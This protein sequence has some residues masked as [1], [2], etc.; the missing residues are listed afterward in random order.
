MPRH[1]I[2]LKFESQTRF[3]SVCMIHEQYQEQYINKYGALLRYGMY[4]RCPLILTYYL[5]GSLTVSDTVGLLFKICN[6]ICHRSRGA[7]AMGRVGRA[8]MHGIHSPR[9]SPSATRTQNRRRKSWR[10]PRLIATA[11]VVLSG[12][13]PR[14]RLHRARPVGVAGCHHLAPCPC[15]R[16]QVTAPTASRSYTERELLPERDV[17]IW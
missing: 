8:R 5:R 4:T 2:V 14:A 10:Q 11:C 13:A 15:C 17:G 16:C 6:C 9:A 3:V 1:E 7:G 12:R